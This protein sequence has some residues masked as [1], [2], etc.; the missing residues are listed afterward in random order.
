[1][2]GDVL[3]L[4]GVAHKRQRLGVVEQLAH[5]IVEPAQ[6]T[7]GMILPRLSGTHVPRFI[8]AGAR[9]RNA[10]AAAARSTARR[11]ASRSGP[12]VTWSTS[13]ASPRSFGE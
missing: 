6:A 9:Q 4:D 7:E 5:V 3:D 11:A 10:H 13:F 1:V 2:F 12:R 8:K